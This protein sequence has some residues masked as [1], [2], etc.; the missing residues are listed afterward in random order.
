MSRLSRWTRAIPG[1]WATVAIERPWRERMQAAP[2]GSVVMAICWVVPWLIEAQPAMMGSSN[3][4]N[5]RMAF[6]AEAYS[7]LTLWM[8]IVVATNL[9]LQWVQ[10]VSATAPDQGEAISAMPR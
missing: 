4:D 3:I 9:R 7:L 2:G 5:P 8:Y 6:S 1:V 10:A